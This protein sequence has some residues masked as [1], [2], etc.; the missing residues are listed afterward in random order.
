[1][2]FQNQNTLGK[3]LCYIS[4]SL[5]FSHWLSLYNLNAIFH[6]IL[7]YI[8]YHFITFL[9]GRISHLFNYGKIFKKFMKQPLTESLVQYSSRGLLSP[10]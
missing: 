5:S 10:A 7:L 9:V 2:H 3:L 4:G 8:F 6:L 1:M